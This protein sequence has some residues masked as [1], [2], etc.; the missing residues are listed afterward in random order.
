MI[1]EATDVERYV[2]RTFEADETEVAETQ[3]AVYQAELESILHRSVEPGEKTE[4]VQVPS[5]HAEI[6]LMGAPVTSITSV[7]L[8][9]DAMNVSLFEVLPRGIGYR[10]G[11]ATPVN[12]LGVFTVV[13]EGGLPASKTVTAKNAVVAR[14]ARFLNK[15]RDDALSAESVSS[16]GYSVKYEADAFSES[17]LRACSRLKRRVISAPVPV[18]PLLGH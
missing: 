3:I 7:H 6:V 13:Y 9:G 10:A 17:E 18:H 2:G 8:D 1:A 11:Y 15:R 12:S 16:E 4:D 5:G 14:T